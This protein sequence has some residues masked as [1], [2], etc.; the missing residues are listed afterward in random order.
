MLSLLS[1]A[2]VLGYRPTPHCYES[3]CVTLTSSIDCLHAAQ[4]ASSGIPRHAGWSVMSTHV[5]P[6]YQ[7]QFTSHLIRDTTTACRYGPPARTTVEAT[8]ITKTSATQF[9][10]HTLTHA[11]LSRCAASAQHVMPRKRASLNT[12]RNNTI[13][14]LLCYGQTQ[15]WSWRG[16]R[17]E[18][19]SP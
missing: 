19:F 14:V 6:G 15:Q 5:F 7:K 3:C 8:T 4:I 16:T 13:R 12:E 18:E 17:V 9:S 11:R 10:L 1:Y 2:Q